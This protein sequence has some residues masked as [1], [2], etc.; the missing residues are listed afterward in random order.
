[1][2]SNIKNKTIKGVKWTS[3]NTIFNSVSYPI[4]QIILATLLLPQDFA[5]IAIISLFISLSVMINNLGIGEAV[6]QKDKVNTQQLSSLFFFSALISIIISSILF[7]TAPYIS[8]YYE[9]QNLEIIVKLIIIT[10]I[11][12]GSTSIFRVILQKN[13]LFKEYS[14]ILMIKILL[15]MVLT[16]TLIISGFG[17]FGYVYGTIGATLIYAIL[18]ITVAL[19]KTEMKILIHFN[20]KDIIPFLNFGFSISLKKILTEITHRIDE[21][22]IGGMLAPEILG[23]YFFGKNLIL[24]LRALITNAFGQILLPVFSKMKSDLV[25]LKRVYNKVSYLIAMVSFPVFV[26]ISLTAH[27]IIP[28]FFGDQ[29]IGSIEVIQVL[30][31]VMIF[32]VLT[33]NIATSLL[34]SLNKP[35]LVLYIDIVS[36]FVYI[37]TLYVFG[38][39]GLQII[40]TLYSLQIIL[41]TVTLQFFVS[42]GLNFKFLKYVFQF[43]KVIFSTVTM[44]FVVVISQILFSEINEFIQLVLSIIIGILV[45]VG[46]QYIID[47]NNVKELLSIFLKRRIKKTT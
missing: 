21:V 34:Y 3:L 23:V 29:W 47:K 19:R 4:Y 41:K 26:G 17:I 36:A 20:M 7:V 35:M 40:L 32:L 16:L 14:I 46:L 31:I 2:E 37:F 33:A 24:H 44:A 25:K 9:L 18:L 38:N 27:L 28:T 43:K 10:I 1:M 6:I 42:K 11:I 45:Y 30:S 8:N 22:I 39:K 12:N 5:Y 13:L 15:D